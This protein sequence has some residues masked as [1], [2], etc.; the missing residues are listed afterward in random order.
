MQGTP[1]S[2]PGTL[3]AACTIDVGR[4]KLQHNY[5]VYS[6]PGL[7]VK[8]KDFLKEGERAVGKEICCWLLPGTGHWVEESKIS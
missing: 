2:C 5:L 3:F 7:T 1:T 8:Q 6:G 4:R